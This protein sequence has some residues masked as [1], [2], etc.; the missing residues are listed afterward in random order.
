MNA[1]LAGAGALSQLERDIGTLRLSLEAQAELR[2][3]RLPLVS[4]ES[5]RPL[6]DFDVEEQKRRLRE[7]VPLR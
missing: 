4:L 6:A 3:R 5:G 7:E 1:W 2:A